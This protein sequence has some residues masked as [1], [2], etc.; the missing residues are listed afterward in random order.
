MFYLS[1]LCLF[2]SLRVFSAFLLFLYVSLVCLS[3]RLSASLLSLRFSRLF[4]FLV[5]LLFSS[6]LFLPLPSFRLSL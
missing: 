1:C 4:V 2:A 6:L 3:L 5:S